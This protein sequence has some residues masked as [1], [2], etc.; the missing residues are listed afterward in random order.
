M[1]VYGGGT[2]MEVEGERKKNALQR[3][4]QQIFFLNIFLNI[5]L[6]RLKI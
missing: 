1:C 6:A 2:E 3:E 4:N 5:F